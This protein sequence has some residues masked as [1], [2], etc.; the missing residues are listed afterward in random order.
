MSAIYNQV[1]FTWLLCIRVI[2]ECRVV[3]L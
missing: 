2:H 3:Y 1:M